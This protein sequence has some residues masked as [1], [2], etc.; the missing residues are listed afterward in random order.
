MREGVTET[1]TLL[2]L[3]KML[4]NLDLV[5]LKNIVVKKRLEVLKVGI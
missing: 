2:R 3:V 4:E 5:N 1:G